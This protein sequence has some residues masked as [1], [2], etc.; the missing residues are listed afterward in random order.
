MDPVYM[1]LH[2]DDIIRR[3][4]EEDITYEDVSTAA[5]CPGPRAA[6]VELIAKAPGVI[7]GLDV[8][9]RAFTLLDPS[10]RVEARVVDGDEVEPG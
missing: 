8:F 9:E 6:T 4:L 1:R 10:T 2:G 3:A 5:V 7:A